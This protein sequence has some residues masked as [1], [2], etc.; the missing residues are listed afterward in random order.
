[1]SF[2]HYVKSDVEQLGYI[3]DADIRMSVR[4]MQV[5]ESMTWRARKEV[6]SSVHHVM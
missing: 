4:G 6:S 2:K 1:M 3:W 5:S